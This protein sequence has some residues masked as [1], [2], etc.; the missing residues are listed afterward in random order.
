MVYVVCCLMCGIR[1]A[2]SVAWCALIDGPGLM[3]FGV[4]CF[5]LAAVCCLLFV[6]RCTVLLV[7]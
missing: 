5:V 3:L 1:C 4:C 7:V 6:I 2:L